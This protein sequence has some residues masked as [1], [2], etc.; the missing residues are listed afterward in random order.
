MIIIGLLKLFKPEVTALVGQGWKFN[1]V[2]LSEGYLF[3]SRV[4]GVVLIFF[5]IL[6]VWFAI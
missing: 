3:L 2:E 4:G 6:F 1:R 5:G